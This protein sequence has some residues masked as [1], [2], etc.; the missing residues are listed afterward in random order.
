M[1]IL[2]QGT[3]AATTESFRATIAGGFLLKSILPYLS[4]IQIG[5]LEKALEEKDSCLRGKELEI[6]KFETTKIELLRQMNAIKKQMQTSESFKHTE[7]EYKRQV[8]DF[9]V[10]V[11]NLRKEHALEIEKLNLE[12]EDERAVETH[13]LDSELERLREEKTKLLDRLRH[14]EVAEGVETGPEEY[15]ELARH[16]EHLVA[17]LEEEK[18]QVMQRVDELSKRLEDERV[19][20]ES[21]E[22]QLGGFLEETQYLLPVNL[23][24]SLEKVGAELRLSLE[25]GRLSVC[26]S[27][28]ETSMPNRLS[29]GSSLGDSCSTTCSPPQ[30]DS[31][32]TPVHLP[33]P[34]VDTPAMQALRDQHRDEME[35]QVS[36][37]REEMD[38][39][40]KYFERV[41]GEQESRYRAEV[42]ELGRRQ[43]PTPAWCALA[44][45]VEIN[46]YHNLII[47][48]FKQPVSLEM[49][50]GQLEFDFESMSPRSGYTSSDTNAQVTNGRTLQRLFNLHFLSL[51]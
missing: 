8:E 3:R 19:A 25:T 13:L 31:E 41:C 18:A 26:S 46:F 50:G 6:S 17:R 42:E 34:E 20:R 11:D 12:W 2:P 45:Q 28:G 47:Y 27:V 49:T 51:I 30:S 15:E 4:C 22:F 1:H 16:Q 37:H 43:I 36:A 29:T 10:E 48:I 14:F 32:K 35:A 9:K 21:I 40:R 23:R 44:S 5:A 7:Q 24:H 39:L 38:T 33:R